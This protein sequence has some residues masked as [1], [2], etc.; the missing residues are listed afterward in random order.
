MK[1]EILRESDPKRAEYERRG[2]SPIATSWGARLEI[3]NAFDFENLEKKI[4][5]CLDSGYELKL[6]TTDYIDQVLELE[7]LNNKDYPYTP[8]TER[9]L[10]L[11]TR[12][13]IA[14]LWNQ[15][16]WNFGVKIDGDLV[17][18]CGTSR[19]WSGIEIDFGSVRADHRG[20]GVGIGGVALAV[21]H[22][23]SLG[24]TKFATGGAALNSAS[25]ATV[26]SLGFKIDE[27]W[28][29]YEVNK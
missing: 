25:K 8:A 29:T 22:L 26:Q 19:K 27:I 7:L 13:K 14:Q 21:Q 10:A 28:Y 3:D 6:L 23:I 16:S 4:K 11:L 20:K 15:N 9:S 24:E 2:D 5:R 17:G 18:V 1:F 12:E